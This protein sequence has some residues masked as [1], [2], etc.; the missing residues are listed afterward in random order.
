M[1]RHPLA[2]NIALEYL[3]LEPEFPSA[4]VTRSEHREHVCP[5]LFAQH[6][7]KISGCETVDWNFA[8][9]ETKAYDDRRL[10]NGPRF[11]P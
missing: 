4:T 5:A 9:L 6:E 7:N 8:R 3:A 11:A 1:P 10:A 2:R